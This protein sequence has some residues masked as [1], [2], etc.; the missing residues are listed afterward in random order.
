MRK[1]YQDMS[2][3]S[4]RAHR[5]HTDMDQEQV[6]QMLCVHQQMS[7]QGVAVRTFHEEEGTLCESYPDE[8]RVKN[9]MVGLAGFEPTTVRL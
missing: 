7:L 2:F 1:V 6:H 9:G 3:G 5:P 8:E 4:D